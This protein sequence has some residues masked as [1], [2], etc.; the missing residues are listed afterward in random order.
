MQKIKIGFDAGK[1][2]KLIEEKQAIKII[3]LKKVTKMEIKDIYMALGWL[4][5]ENKVHFFEMD[6]EMAV[7]LIY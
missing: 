5:R 3:D 7:N 6:G 4:A 1:L 2:Y